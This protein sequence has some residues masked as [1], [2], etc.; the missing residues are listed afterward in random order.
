MSAPCHTG[1]SDTACARC[2]VMRACL[3]QVQGPAQLVASRLVELVRRS[4]VESTVRPNSRRHDPPWVQ[5]P[6]VGRIRRYTC[7]E[8]QRILGAQIATDR[9]IAGFDATPRTVE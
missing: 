1:G 8:C 6:L 5:K 3:A 2:A 4:G 7:A 9:Y